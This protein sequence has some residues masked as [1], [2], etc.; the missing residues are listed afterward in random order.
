MIVTHILFLAALLQMDETA[1][2][3]IS[4]AQDL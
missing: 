2:K 1:P 4:P 3:A